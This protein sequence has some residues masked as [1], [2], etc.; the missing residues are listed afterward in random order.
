[1][2]KQILNLGKVLNKATQ[3]EVNGGILRPIQQLCV[4]TGTGGG[5]SE[6][7]STA[8]IGKPAGFK[9]TIN[10]YL[11]ACSGNGTGFWFY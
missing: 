7:S 11:A 4:G 9:C 5:S 2:K 8:C 1:M 3:Q 10:G 6:G